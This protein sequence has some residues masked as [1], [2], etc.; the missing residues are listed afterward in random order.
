MEHDRK[1]PQAVQLSCLTETILLNHHSVPNPVE[2]LGNVGV[3]LQLRQL[4][5][6]I[7]PPGSIASPS[8][9]IRLEL[10]QKVKTIKSKWVR[11]EKAEGPLSKMYSNPEKKSRCRRIG[12]REIHQQRIQQNFVM[13]IMEYVQ[14]QLSHTVQS[15]SQI[16]MRAP[17]YRREFTNSIS[18]L[19]SQ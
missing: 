16:Q 10:R 6:D 7:G 5:N 15:T 4:E 12:P 3:R 1:V 11:P 18:I 17:K 19:N 13:T 2:P 8:Q 14:A 9:R